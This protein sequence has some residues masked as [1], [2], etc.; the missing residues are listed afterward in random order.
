[1]KAF[2]HLTGGALF[3][4]A[5]LPLAACSSVPSAPLATRLGTTTPAIAVAI[6]AGE[7]A[8]IPKV[9]R[10]Y[11]IRGQWYTPAEQP[12]YDETGTGSWYGEAFQGKPTA[13]GEVFDMNQV[14]A[15]HKT[16]PL[17]SMVEVTNLDNGKSLT[18]RV[19]DRGPFVDG[20]IIDLSKGAADE[21]GVLRPGL[22]RVR[23][24]YV[25][26]APAVTET[27][28]AEARGAPR[29]RETPASSAPLTAFAIAPPPP[30]PEF[31]DVRSDDAPT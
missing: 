17:P 23:V 29:R 22:A 24:R 11:E 8:A 18:V 9:G 5:L 2:K 13:N 30:Q 27:Q 4:S 1:M 26:P 14:S 15:A 10:P 20:R 21:L 16:L 19:N 25:G 31:A 6:P 12:D 3:A 28:I 7:I